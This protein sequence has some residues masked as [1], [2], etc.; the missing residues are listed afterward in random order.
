M[1]LFMFT[2]QH[3]PEHCPE[4]ADEMAKHYETRQPSGKLNV[5][6]TCGNGEHRMF[7]FI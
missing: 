1:G 3:N 4:L 5:Y 6:C 7:F 2:D